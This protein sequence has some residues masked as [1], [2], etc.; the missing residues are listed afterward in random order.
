MSKQ[1][2]FVGFLVGLAANIAGVF[3]YISVFSEMNIDNTLADAMRNEYLG[4]L[5]ALGA[6]LN[7]LPFFVFLKKNQH[8]HA[9]GVLLATI[10]VAIAI[11][12]YKI[13]S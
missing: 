4:K 13:V 6:I 10:C 2:L 3:L 5:I 8:Y 11:A 7:F 9:R 12:I 1:D